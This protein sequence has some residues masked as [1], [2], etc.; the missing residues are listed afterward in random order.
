TDLPEKM[1]WTRP[2]V[3][4]AKA[5]ADYRM[6]LFENAIPVLE[7][8]AS[9]VLVPAP[10]LVLAMAQFRMGKADDARRTLEAAVGQFDWNLTKAGNREAWMNHVLRRE[11]ESTIGPTSR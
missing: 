5:L 11:A 2:Y 4:F 8:E 9:G 7:G 1:K 10:K 6:G 3:L